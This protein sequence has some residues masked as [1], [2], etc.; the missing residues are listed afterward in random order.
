MYYLVFLSCL[1]SFGNSHR[2]PKAQPS[3]L[4]QKQEQY[5]PATSCPLLPSLCATRKVAARTSG[6]A[7][8]AG[9]AAH[10]GGLVGGAAVT[11]SVVIFAAANLFS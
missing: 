11:G 7:P 2:G 1:L 5:H 10:T 8:W 6:A 4:V 3:F 9:D